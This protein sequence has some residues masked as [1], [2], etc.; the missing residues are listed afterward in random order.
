MVQF[1][2]STDISML[3]YVML[4]MFITHLSGSLTCCCFAPTP[5]G[6]KCQ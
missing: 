4:I 1:E 2:Y 3:S 5:S 6:Y